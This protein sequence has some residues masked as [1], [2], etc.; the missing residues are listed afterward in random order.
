MKRNQLPILASFGK[1]GEQ[2]TF[3]LGVRERTATGTV[4]ML[5]ELILLDSS[6]LSRQFAYRISPTPEFQN[7]LYFRANST[8]QEIL[9]FPTHPDSQSRFTLRVTL[10][11]DE[12]DASPNSTERLAETV[13][14]FMRLGITDSSRSCCSTRE[15]LPRVSLCGATRS[16]WTSFRRFTCLVNLK[17]VVPTG[18]MKSMTDRYG[19]P[20]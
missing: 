15:S 17:L 9:E 10:P 13:I 6:N 1:E 5:N 20:A 11:I 12:Q 3:G 7:H 16:P 14:L 19:F 2:L 4:F 18:T 8:K